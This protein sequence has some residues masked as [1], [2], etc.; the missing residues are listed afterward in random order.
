M[1]VYV[2]NMH[3]TEMGRFG[4]YRMCHMLADSTEELLAMADRIGVDQKYIQKAGTPHEHF[5]IPTHRRRLAVLYGA[6]EIT[7]LEAGRFVGARRKAQE[8]R[9]AAG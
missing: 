7:M 1:A 9:R 4:R 3:L 8:A 6:V 2:D 5:D